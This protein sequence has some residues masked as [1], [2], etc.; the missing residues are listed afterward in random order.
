[1]TGCLSC[2]QEN[3][4]LRFVGLNVRRLRLVLVVE[5]FIMHDA[6]LGR[7]TPGPN[8]TEKAN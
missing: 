3:D 8:W 2:N 6:S 4:G 5:H 7:L 1:M